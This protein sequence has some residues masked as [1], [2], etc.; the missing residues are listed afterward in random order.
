MRRV[1]SDVE[2]IIQRAGVP[3]AELLHRNLTEGPHSDA[4][5]AAIELKTAQDVLNR[6]LGKPKERVD[7]SVEVTPWER[8]TAVVVNRRGDEPPA[9]PSPADDDEPFEDDE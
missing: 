9:L 4:A 1:L 8:L 2:A 7:V 6:L 5:R 3:A